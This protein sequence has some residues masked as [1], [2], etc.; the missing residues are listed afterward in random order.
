MFGSSVLV[1]N[2]VCQ[3]NIEWKVCAE[4]VASCIN[5]MWMISFNENFNWDMSLSCIMV[6]CF[7]LLMHLGLYILI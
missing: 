1:V 5:N 4:N 7:E 3:W 6:C 2:L